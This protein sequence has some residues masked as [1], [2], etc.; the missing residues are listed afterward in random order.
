MLQEG[1]E[2]VE[3]PRFHGGNKQPDKH[4]EML[5]NK[6]SSKTVIIIVLLII[7]AI[8]AVLLGAYYY[9]HSWYKGRKL[10]FR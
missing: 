10:D 9:R 1:D 7:F 5:E 4:N 8:V 6:G 3:D 2:D